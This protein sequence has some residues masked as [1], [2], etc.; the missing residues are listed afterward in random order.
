MTHP[1]SHISFSSTGVIRFDTFDDLYTEPQLALAELRKRRKDAQLTDLVHRGLNGFAK[2]FL[3]RHSRPRAVLFRQLATPTHETI[4]FLRLAKNLGL[5]PLILEYLGD[6]FV[7]TGNRYKRSLGKMPIYQYTGADGRDM[8]RYKSVCDFNRFTG[9]AIS[10]VECHS[11]E[12]LVALHHRLLQSVTKLDPR[13]YCID[14]TK[15][16]RGVGKKAEN[17][18]E[19]FLRLF[20]RDAVLFESFV[21]FKAEGSFTN[22]IIVPSFKAVFSQYGLRPL[23]VRLLPDVDETRLFWDS[24]PKKV[25]QY[26]P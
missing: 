6:K 5:D 9:K 17:Y 2:E 15:W 22:S 13:K 14:G 24:F 8:F 23:I 26:T 19:N 20:I 21:P 7:S 3:K 16:F 10:S 18:Y 11:G 4:R 25:E 1:L 12:S